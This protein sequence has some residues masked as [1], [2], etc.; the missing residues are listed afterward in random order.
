MLD[1]RMSGERS[2]DASVS[3]DAPGREAPLFDRW[4]TCVVEYRDELELPVTHQALAGAVHLGRHRARLERRGLV[5]LHTV[6]QEA[7]RYVDLEV[8]RDMLGPV[9]GMPGASSWK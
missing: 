5:D 9:L 7:R 1:P 8:V 3:S 2:P 6:L 4:R